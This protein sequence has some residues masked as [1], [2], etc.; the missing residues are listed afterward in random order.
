MLGHYDQF[1]SACD[2]FTV[3]AATLRTYYV[4]FFIE[5]G[6]RRLVFWNVSDSLDGIWTAQQFRNLSVT[7]D[8]LPRY[9]L[10]DRDS[11]FTAHADALL[12]DVGTEAIRLPARSPNLNA[13]AERWIRT[14]RDECLG[15]IIGLNEIYLRWVLTEFI[16]YYNERRPHRSLGLRPPGGPAGYSREGEVTRRQVLGGLITDYYRKAA[17]QQDQG[18]GGSSPQPRGDGRGRSSVLRHPNQSP[19][20]D[21]PTRHTATRP[22]KVR[23]RM[24]LSGASPPLL[25][26][27]AVPVGPRSRCRLVLGPH[28]LK[29]VHQLSL[30]VPSSSPGCWSASG[31]ASASA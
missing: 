14:V 28:E 12:G 9:L 6:T 31:C 7:H 18:V 5:I 17:R 21:L 22:T 2:F 1:I 29:Q 8:N 26:P 16:Q 15:R 24:F 25:S 19:V 10:H 3:T 11:K 20:S 4:L 23:F 27:W 30:P 13:H